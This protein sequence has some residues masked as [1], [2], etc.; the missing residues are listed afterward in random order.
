MPTEKTIPLAGPRLIRAEDLNAVQLSGY[1]PTF[2]LGQQPVVP[3]PS[4]R[5]L[6]AL[7]EIGRPFFEEQQ[8]TAGASQPLPQP[9]LA[10]QTPP[11]TY[12][13][14]PETQIL[15]SLHGAGL[16]FV[17]GLGSRGAGNRVL[18]GSWSGVSPSDPAV[19]LLQTYRSHF[20]PL[21]AIRVPDPAEL[22]GMQSFGLVLGLPGRPIAEGG[23]NG[24]DLLLRAMAGQTWEA[25]IMAAPVDEAT[26]VA[27]RARLLE[28]LR[29]VDA[30]ASSA[31]VPSRLTQLYVANIERHLADLTHG[32]GVGVWRVATYLMATQSSFGQLAASWRGLFSGTANDHAPLHVLRHE[33]IAAWIANWALPEDRND[34]LVHPF[35]YQTLVNSAQLATIASLPSRETS[36]F[37]RKRSARFDVAQAHHRRT[38]E[39]DP[40]VLGSIQDAGM[41]QGLY[42]LKTSALQRHAF[43]SGVTGSGKTNT[44]FQILKQIDRDRVPFLILEPAKSEYRAFA[45]APTFKNRFRIYTVGDERVAPLRMNPFEVLGWPAIPVSVHLDLLRSCFAA[46]FGMWTPLPQILEQCLHEIYKDRGWNVVSNKNSR[47]PEGA[48]PAPAFPTLSDLAAKID[49][50]ITSLG[51]EDRVRADMR[52][53]LLTRIKGLQTGGKGALFDSAHSTPIADLLTNPTVLELQNLGDDDDKAFFMALLFARLVEYRR[54]QGPSASGLKHVLV[55]EE[56]HRLLTNVG[57]PGGAAQGEQADPKGKAVESFSNLISEI[58]AYGQGLIVVDQVPSKLAPDVIKNTNLKVIHRIVAEDDRA[59]LSGAT[60]MSEEQRSALSILEVGQAVA[61]E[62]GEDGPLLLTIPRAKDF[63]DEVQVTD[64]Q[65]RLTETALPRSYDLC[66]GQCSATAAECGAAREASDNILLQR[67][68]AKVTLSLFGTPGALERLRPDLDSVIQ[69]RSTTRRANASCLHMHLC[70]GL[71]ERWGRRLGWTF[72]ETGL[73]AAGLR[74]LWQSNVG[75]IQSFW[76]DFGPMLTT[77]VSPCLGCRVSA[78]RFGDSSPCSMRTAVEELV[79][80]GTFDKAFTEATRADDRADGPLRNTY[81][82]CNDAAFELIEFPSELADEAAREQITRH[83]RRTLICFAESML[84][85]HYQRAPGVMQSQLLHILE[86]DERSIP[87]EEDNPL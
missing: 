76:R 74:R 57:R 29:R 44:L 48:N 53:A 16:N 67:T 28:D 86:T 45:S 64:E 43:V 3:A 71:A 52:A 78:Q 9:Q 10:G 25:R 36:G 30:S 58:R 84:E 50:Y 37:A 87:E 5:V 15:T 63:P 49:V 77:G 47:L 56:A 35:S 34:N 54:S 65:L 7:D 27:M 40:Q 4:A 81:A 82:V 39:G 66:A 12:S 22:Q 38:A 69:M 8:R 70:Y 72:P 23:P 68:F 32:F 51:Y 19:I 60:A 17:F 31:G 6:F 73:F 59:I 79:D 11:Q 14:S 75:D 20:A 61:F 24:A 1:Q 2:V 85:R 46:S 26:L 62:D 83:A 80:S 33:N 55:I 18:I 21:R 41:D 42:A 13:T